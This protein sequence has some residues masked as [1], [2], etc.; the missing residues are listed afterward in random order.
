[1]KNKRG[2]STVIATVLIILITVVAAAV[3]YRSIMSFVKIGP[4]ST[5][6]VPYRE[7]LKFDT[8]MDY[9]CY[10]SNS[11]L[12]FSIKALADN[13][14][15]QEITNFSVKFIG[16]GVTKTVKVGAGASTSSA[17]GEVRMLDSSIAKI[18]VPASGETQT[19]VFNTGGENYSRVE[20]YPVL[21]NGKICDR[22]DSIDLEFCLRTSLGS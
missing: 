18:A 6:C 2:I 5:S 17:S 10:D 19:Y 12:G 11:R 3:L 1:M 16:D 8:S 14:D 15:Q 20:V 9:N 4:E 7:Y 13:T 21:L 22:S